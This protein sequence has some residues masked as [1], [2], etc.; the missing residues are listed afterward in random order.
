M[1]DLTF[2][3]YDQ[4]LAALKQRI[5]TA[6]IK[7][8]LAVNQALVMLYWQIGRE[9]IER[10]QQQSWGAKVVERLSRD[11]RQ[12]FPGMKGFSV[13]NLKYMRAFAEAYP[14]EQIVQQIVAQISWG[15]NVCFLKWVL[16]KAGVTLIDPENLL[17]S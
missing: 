13:R 6:Q 16:P 12:E 10:Q 7:V 14:E 2:T 11:L 1:A 8:V 5:R 15:Y 3:D 17:R 9:I 4:F